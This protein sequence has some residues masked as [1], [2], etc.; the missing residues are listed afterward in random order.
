MEEPDSRYYQ[1]KE[2]RE[3]DF[4]KFDAWEFYNVV[5]HWPEFDPQ[6]VLTAADERILRDVAVTEVNLSND[7]PV[8]TIVILHERGIPLNGMYWWLAHNHKDAAA[9]KHIM[10]LDDAMKQAMAKENITAICY[11]AAVVDV[12][13]YRETL[14]RL[15]QESTQWVLR[16]GFVDRMML[17]R[18][19]A[20]VFGPQT[21]PDPV[22]RDQ[23]QKGPAQGLMELLSQPI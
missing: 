17:N 12:R 7:I 6:L 23:V 10:T 4:T 13:P 11:L 22:L 19:I 14:M 16:D 1:H 8:Q 21:I 15:Q 3:S 5:K 18:L 20:N 2:L 9:V